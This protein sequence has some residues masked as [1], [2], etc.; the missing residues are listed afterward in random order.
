[1]GDRYHRVTPESKSL[2][3][4]ESHK[5][6]KS[7]E[8]ST[9]NVKQCLKEYSLEDKVEGLKNM[10]EHNEKRAEKPEPRI[11]ETCTKERIIGVKECLQPHSMSAFQTIVSEL[12]NT[13]MNSYWN[14]E[15]GKTR[16][17]VPNL[18]AGMDPLEV[19][20]GKK[21]VSTGT[22]ADAL[23]EMK[24]SDMPEK[25]VHEMY[26]KSHH[27]YLPAERIERRYKK[28]FEKDMCFGESM[29]ILGIVDGARLKRLVKWI[30]PEPY[31]TV[32]SN[33]ADFLER[34]HARVGET[35]NIK[36]SYMYMDMKHGKTTAK[37]KYEKLNIMSDCPV[38]ND[39]LMQQEYLQYINSLRLRF[40]K[41]VPPVPF[42]D[43]HEDLFCQDENYTDVLPEDKIYSTLARYRV[44]INKD[45]LTPL[46]DL[47]QIRKEK[48]VKYKELLDLL[49]WKYHF[50]TLPK[51]ERI[52]RECQYFDTSYGSTIGSVDKIDTTDVRTAGILSIDPD[53]P[54]A[55]SL[56]FPNV[57]TKHGLSHLELI[58]V[59]LKNE[60]RNIFE[61]IG[62]T[63]PENNFDVLWEEGT[64]ISG[65]D[66]V[67]VEIF[68]NLLEQFSNLISDKYDVKPETQ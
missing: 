10:L 60:V 59:R 57:Y 15:V 9:S 51:I 42:T 14:Q 41:L 17:Q 25:E 6:F 55:Y 20:F 54:T 58:K 24:V 47:L 28:P 49:N 61:R 37:D 21:L 56:I 11:I 7:N 40:K 39:V 68:L 53:Q 16:Y 29:D 30:N 43:I 19:T 63:F 65:T 64:K 52:P 48:N 5:K 1:M 34:T 66:D 35:K 33:L 32:S 3:N 13:V 23:Q 44:H 8:A 50:P 18:P 4:T 46:L 22:V 67:S 26:I 38:N 36:N 2:L 45:L 12:R 31:A 62:I 27:D